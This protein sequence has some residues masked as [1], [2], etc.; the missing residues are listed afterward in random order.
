MLILKIQDFSPDDF[1]DAIAQSVNSGFKAIQRLANNWLSGENRFDRQGEALFVAKESDR[2]IG[3][4]GLNI[5]PYIALSV[6][7]V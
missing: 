2:I 5:D 3:I 6:F 1:D 4:C 7:V